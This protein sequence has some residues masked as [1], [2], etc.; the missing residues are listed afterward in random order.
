MK[1]KEC[2]D[3]RVYQPLI[4]PPETCRAC[5]LAPDTNISQNMLYPIVSLNVP[6]TITEDQ[7]TAV[8]DDII[9]SNAIPCTIKVNKKGEVTRGGPTVLALR[10][11]KDCCPDI[12]ATLVPGNMLNVTM[13]DA[14]YADNYVIEKSRIF[15]QLYGGGDDSCPLKDFTV[16]AEP[17]DTAQ[18]RFPADEALVSLM[19]TIAAKRANVAKDLIAATNEARAKEVGLGI[20]KELRRAN[21]KKTKMAAQAQEKQKKQVAAETRRAM[22][23]EPPSMMGTV[24]SRLYAESAAMRQRTASL[25]LCLANEP[26]EYFS[27]HAQTQW[28]KARRLMATVRKATMEIRHCAN[29]IRRDQS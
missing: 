16:V 27:K 3:T 13:C 2:R 26:P 6:Y 14:Q 5:S 23:D 19:N 25:D 9:F 28:L 22:T 18:E 24:E 20:K 7:L 4:G 15:A 21:H 8:L 29:E 11:L 12:Y 10:V 17:Q 1:C